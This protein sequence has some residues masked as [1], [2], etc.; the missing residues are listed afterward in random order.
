MGQTDKLRALLAEEG[1]L[2]LPGCFDAL[3]A[4]LIERAGYS[5]AFMGGFAVSASRLGAP[6]TGLISYSEMLD[7]AA[8]SVPPSISPSLATGTPGMAT[9]S[10]CSAR[11]RAMPTPASPA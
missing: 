7:Q 9:P 2:V 11:L 6:D 10:T 3:T 1:A 4:R 8:T 5:G